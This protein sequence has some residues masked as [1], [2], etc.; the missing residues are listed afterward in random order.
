MENVALVDCGFSDWFGTRD[1]RVVGPFPS[2]A[3]A[4]A[5]VDRLNERALVA[6]DGDTV[7]AVAMTLTTPTAPAEFRIA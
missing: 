4:Q 2:F 3:V 6:R 7:R 5:W 1:V